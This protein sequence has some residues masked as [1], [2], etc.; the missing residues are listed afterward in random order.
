MRR[1]GDKSTSFSKKKRT[2]GR[3]IVHTVNFRKMVSA[4]TSGEDGEGG[5]KV[6]LETWSMLF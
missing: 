4:R 1:Y 6:W 2:W 3:K 5:M